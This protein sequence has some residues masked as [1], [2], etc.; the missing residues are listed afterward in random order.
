MLHRFNKASWTHPML[1][2][3]VKRLIDRSSIWI[4]FLLSSVSI[5]NRCSVSTLIFILRC[6]DHLD[7]RDAQ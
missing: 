5:S 4:E 1:S 6:S 7:H 3:L 2:N